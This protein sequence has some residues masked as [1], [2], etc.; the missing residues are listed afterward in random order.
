MEFTEIEI[1]TGKVERRKEWD[2]LADALKK[3]T[4]AIAWP[5]SVKRMGIVVA[6]RH[7]GLKVK[8]RTLSADTIAVWIDRNGDGQ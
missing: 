1:P 4:K 7:R 3:T 2:E 6:M 5:T 8:T